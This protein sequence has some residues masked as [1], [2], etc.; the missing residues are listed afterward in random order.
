MWGDRGGKV[1]RD[2]GMARGVIRLLDSKEPQGGRVAS[3]VPNRR[4]AVV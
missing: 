2:T 4:S 3:R 1:V